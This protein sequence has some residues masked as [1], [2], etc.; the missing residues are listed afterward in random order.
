VARGVTGALLRALRARSRRARLASSQSLASRDRKLDREGRASSGRGGDADLAAHLPRQRMRD[1]EA[2][3]AAA[4]PPCQ[5][6]VGAEEL[7]EDARLGLVRDSNPLVADGDPGL[8]LRIGER[9]GA[10]AAARRVV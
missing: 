4:D 2:E 3:A 1:V 9:V 10:G 7:L 6:R 5:A 8:T